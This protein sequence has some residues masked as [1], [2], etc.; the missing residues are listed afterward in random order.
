[1]TD[2]NEPD[3]VKDAAEAGPIDTEPTTPDEDRKSDRTPTHPGVYLQHFVD[4]ADF[5]VRDLAAITDVS[6]TKL[7]K[8]LNKEWSVDTELAVKLSH[9]FEPDA[10]FWVKKAKNHELHETKQAMGDEAEEIKMRLEELRD[11]DELTTA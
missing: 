6:H 1:M 3:W 7:Y 9:V 10:N 8:I 11:N 4:Q 2:R 5:G